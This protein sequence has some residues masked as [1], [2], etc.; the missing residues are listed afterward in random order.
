M[1]LRRIKVRVLALLLALTLLPFGP[2]CPREAR[3]VQSGADFLCAKLISTGYIPLRGHYITYQYNGETLAS[4]QTS[5]ATNLA[6]WKR[7]SDADRMK[8]TKWFA[9]WSRDQIIQFGTSGKRQMDDWALT[10]TGWKQAGQQLRADLM[11]KNY[12]ALYAWYGDPENPTSHA[13]DASAYNTLGFGEYSAA[14]KAEMDSLLNRYGVA[15]QMGADAY[16]KLSNLK[17]AQTNVA[18][19]F[20]SSELI[21]IIMDNA[22]SPRPSGDLGDLKD[23]IWEITDDQLKITDKIK[24]VTGLRYLST[25][26]VIDD[27]T[28]ESDRIE[29]EAAINAIRQ[30]E[31]LMA[32]QANLA[33]EMMTFCQLEANTLRS[34]YSKLS[35]DDQQRRALAQTQLQQREAAEQEARALGTTANPDFVPNISH[36]VK[37]S[38]ESEETFRARQLAAAK[39]WANDQL[40]LAKKDA[41]SFKTAYTSDDGACAPQTLRWIAYDTSI[42][43]YNGVEYPWDTFYQSCFSSFLTLR[44]Y[45]GSYRVNGD[46]SSPKALFSLPNYKEL[47]SAQRTGQNNVLRELRTRLS[48]VNAF[49]SAWETR[50]TSYES[51]L[52]PL[53]NVVFNLSHGAEAAYGNWRL[54]TSVY[55]AFVDTYCGATMDVIRQRIEYGYEYKHKLETVI[56]KKTAELEDFNAS[57]QTFES[58]LSKV[59]AVYKS[60]QEDMEYAMPLLRQEIDDLFALRASYPDWL[61]EYSNISYQMQNRDY[62]HGMVPLRSGSSLCSF[63]FGGDLATDLSRNEAALQNLYNAVKDYPDDEAE[64]INNA[65]RLTLM[66]DTARSQREEIDG[67]SNMLTKTELANMNALFGGSLKSYKDLYDEYGLLND[68]GNTV[69]MYYDSYSSGLRETYSVNNRVYRCLS[70]ANFQ[71]TPN[72]MVAILVNELEGKSLYLDDMRTLRE[73]LLA[74]RASLMEKAASSDESVRQQ[75]YRRIRYYELKGCRTATSTPQYNEYLNN[76]GSLAEEAY[77]H[78]YNF[79]V[80][81]EYYAAYVKPIVDELYA[82]FNGQAGYNKVTGITG[83]GPT[84]MASLNAALQSGGRATLPVTLKTSNSKPATIPDILWKSSDESVVTVDNTGV[85]TALAPGSATVTATALGSPDIVLLTDSDGKLTG[86]YSG[87]Y[88]VSYSISVKSDGI[89]SV[90]EMTQDFKLAGPS[91]SFADKKLSFHAVLLYNGIYAGDEENWGDPPQ[92]NAVAAFYDKNGR[93]LGCGTD[94]VTLAKGHGTELSMVIPLSSLPSGGV[95]VKLLLLDVS[96]APLPDYEPL[97]WS[98]G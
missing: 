38:T 67:E 22:L 64:H 86:E 34:K 95:K 7:M 59:N 94:G 93:F 1:K 91:I 76:E 54:D 84:L 43:S 62:S 39:E 12:P 71:T 87:G 5:S 10:R 23:K 15:E 83:G 77:R 53:K 33:E 96:S 9:G 8:V 3:A 57:V 63:W 19:T 29:G 52:V 44:N 27:F 20:I 78:T 73:K 42:V 45:D 41:Q 80:V 4:D 61:K 60:S 24:E 66:I 85:I 36:I 14:E 6:A 82:V 65:C 21:K 18:V 30:F 31:R 40:E 70:Y 28:G 98:T 56:A 74:E 69:V 58:Y 50:L 17:Y 47:V 92:L 51:N 89:A 13:L 81:E 11:R 37:Q 48:E 75:A 97:V 25:D 2:L 79:A 35:A 90:S 55:N 26:D 16:R 88:T 49:I 32:V 46:L 68:N 72:T